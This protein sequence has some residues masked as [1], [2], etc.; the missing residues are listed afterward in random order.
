[1]SYE[2]FLNGVKQTRATT[3]SVRLANPSPG[4]YTMTVVVSDPSGLTAQASISFTV[5][6]TPQNKPPVIQSIEYDPSN[7]I[8]GQLVRF[9]ANAYDENGRIVTYEWDFGS[10]FNPI[11]YHAEEQPEYAWPNPGTYTVCLTVYDNDGASTRKCRNITVQKARTLL[12][13]RANFT[14]SPSSPKV[15]EIVYFKDQSDDPDGRIEMR[16]WFLNEQ[17][18]SSDPNPTTTFQYAGTYT[19]CLQVV[20]NDLLN[21]EKCTT[22]TVLPADKPKQRPNPEFSISNTNPKVGETVYFRD[23]STDDNRIVQWS[24]NFGNGRYSNEQNPTQTYSAAGTYN[25]CLT[26]TD[27]DGLSAERCY[28]LTVRPED[29]PK[30]SPVARFTITAPTGQTIQENGELRLTV[31]KGQ[32]ISF[33]FSASNSYDPDGGG[34]RAYQWWINGTPVSQS[35]QFQS[36]KLG[37][38]TPQTPEHLIHLRVTDDEGQSAEVGAKVIITEQQATCWSGSRLSKSA[39]AE[40]VKQYFPDNVVPQTG[41]NIRV[42]AYAVARAESGGDPTACGD[43]NQSIGLWQIYLPAHPQYDRNRLFDSNYNAQAAKEISNNGANW[44]AWCTWEK[45]ACNGSGNL[46]YRQ[47][48]DEARQAL[49]IVTPAQTLHLKAPWTAGVTATVGGPGSFYGENFHVG[50]IYYSIDFNWDND[51]GSPVRAAYGGTIKEIGYKQCG[52]GGYGNYVIID[53]GNGFTTLYAH[54]KY[55][56]KENP[57]IQQNQ[58][59]EQGWIIGFVGSTPGGKC[60]SGPHLHFELRK[61]NKT[62]VIDSMEGIAIKE[63]CEGTTSCASDGGKITSTNMPTTPQDKTLVRAQGD[64]RVYWL[65]NGKRYWVYDMATLDAMKAMPNWGWDSSPD[66]ARRMAHEF[67]SSVLNRYREGPCIKL[68]MQNTKECLSEGLLVRQKGTDSVYVIEGG[69]KRHVKFEEFQFERKF[70]WKDVIE[71]TS[72]FAQSLGIVNDAIQLPPTT[73][74]IEQAIAS[75]VPNDPPDV[76]NPDLVIGDLEMMKA[77]GFYEKQQPVPNTDG[78]I[79]DDATMLRLQDLWISRRPVSSSANLTTSET[80]LRQECGL[81]TRQLDRRTIEFIALGFDVR[82]IKVEIFNLQGQRVFAEEAPSNRLTF[83]GQDS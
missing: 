81:L 54:L 47:Y 56:P 79:I 5:R 78:Q 51:D 46:K 6:E 32:T 45:T 77:L 1:M 13:P 80:R 63:S 37:A 70:D 49:G 61:D 8:A 17:F 29:K 58:Q 62:V 66:R 75:L 28:S 50:N 23:R 44:N 31:N 64:Y 74:T 38:N 7:P 9:W 67:P 57:G 12:P 34:I 3:S 40:L 69:Q 39:L 20:D 68:G 25:V 11:F 21:D 18:F 73:K 30:Q 24:W 36:P 16:G 19:V 53:H 52:S 2:W 55:D 10:F 42:T 27:N 82:S 33:N 76:A 71:I 43:N 22:I 26:V 35:S 59:V 14:F 65:Q 83:R 41:E 48:L 15:G 60:S 72:E 4:S